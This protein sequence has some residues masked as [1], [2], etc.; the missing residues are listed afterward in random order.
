MLT[1]KNMLVSSPSRSI[2]L[3]FER[4]TRLFGDANLSSEDQRCI[5]ALAS[6]E[7]YCG[8]AWP[9]KVCQDFVLGLEYHG[10]SFTEPGNYQERLNFY[11][12]MAISNREGLQ[13]PFHSAVE[14]FW[15]FDGC[16]NPSNYKEESEEISAGGAQNAC[17]TY[18]TKK[19]Q[20]CSRC[21]VVWY[22]SRECQLA[23]FKTLKRIARY[24]Q[25]A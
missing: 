21:L 13:Y 19:L 10:A 8:Y 17:H 18:D 11:K 20:T 12:D 22:C 3:L 25:A 24:G 23:H 1:K 16:D 6:N 15:F 2:F 4:F 14:N 7:I 5:F 9:W